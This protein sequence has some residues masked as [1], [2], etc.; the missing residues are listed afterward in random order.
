MSKLWPI[1]LA[2]LAP[3]RSPGGWPIPFLIQPLWNRLDLQHAQPLIEGPH[4]RLRGQDC[5]PSSFLAGTVLFSGIAAVLGRV[6]ALVALAVVTLV[7]IAFYL[8]SPA[9]AC[10]IADRES[11]GAGSKP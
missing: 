3:F 7:L 8:F 2:S 1:P 9:P 10:K 5:E 4:E 11:P 6:F